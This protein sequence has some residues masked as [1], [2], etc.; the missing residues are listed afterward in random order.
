MKFNEITISMINYFCD[1]IRSEKNIFNL[2][3]EDFYY[4]IKYIAF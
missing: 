4:A 2:I 3:E 1:K